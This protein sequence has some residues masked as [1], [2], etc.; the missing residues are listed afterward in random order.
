MFSTK[1]STFLCVLA[2][3]VLAYGLGSAP[4]ARV[5]PD[6]FGTGLAAFHADVNSI[7]HGGFSGMY[8]AGLEKIREMQAKVQRSKDDSTR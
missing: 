5:L 7:A 8:Y 3:V 2:P 1:L 4:V 6:N